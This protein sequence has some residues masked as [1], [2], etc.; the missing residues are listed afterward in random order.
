MSKKDRL[1]A[2]PDWLVIVLCIV[3]TAVGTLA[4]WIVA[5]RGGL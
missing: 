5:A 3:L 2:I 4:L 1:P